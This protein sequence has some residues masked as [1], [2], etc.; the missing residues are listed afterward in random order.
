VP[1]PRAKLGDPTGPE[2]VPSQPS[3]PALEKSVLAYW[4]AEGSFVESVEQRE[5]GVNGANEFVFYDGPPFANGLPRFPI[6]GIC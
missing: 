5:A 4:D 2:A 3:F 6:T 1:Y